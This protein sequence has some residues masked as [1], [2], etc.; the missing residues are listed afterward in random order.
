VWRAT[1]SGLA[2]CLLACAGPSAPEL[3]VSLYQTRSDTPADKLEIQVRNAGQA[4]VTVQ[5]ARLDSPRLAAPA[6]WDEPVEIPPGAA[7][8]LKVDLPGPICGARGAE[9]VMLAVEGTDLELDAPDTLGQV[10]AYADQTCF[11]QEVD[12]TSVIRVRKVTDTGM[13]V[14]TDPGQAT[15][16]EL[17]TTILF[18]PR[19]PGALAAPAGDRTRVREVRLRPNRCEAHAL[20]E[21]KQGT[22]FDVAVTLPDGRSGT[23]ALQMGPRV[24][25]RLYTLYARLCG[26]E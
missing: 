18:A 21:D 12:S 25:A 9:R 4:P 26:L 2:L 7:V 17:D 3:T 1:A 11:E 5:R 23:Y 10:A 20:A 16:G 14:V 22:V 13:R 24:R 19:D 15:I 8:D 6:T